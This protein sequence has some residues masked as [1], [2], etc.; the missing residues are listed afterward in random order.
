MD[1][2]NTTLKRRSTLRV[3]A[4]SDPELLM[5]RD[6][7]LD[8][9]EFVHLALPDL[10]LAAVDTEVMFLGRRL[11]APLVITSQAGGDGT[12]INRHLAV[13]AQEAGVALAL[14]P[15][16]IALTDDTALADFR[17]RDQ[18]PEIPVYAQLE[19]C[20][21]DELCTVDAA[22]EL[23]AKLDADALILRLNAFEEALAGIESITAAGA[24]ARIGAIVEAMRPDNI[25]VMV[26]EPGFGL[27][28]AASRALMDLRVD[29]V[30]VSGAGGISPARCAARLSQEPGLSRVGT[31]FGDWG[32]SLVDSI[33]QIRTVSD[34]LPIVAGG[35]VR[36]G[37]DAAKLLALGSDVISLS[38]PF[39][40]A[41]AQGPE[42]VVQLCQQL[43]TELRLTMYGVGARSIEELRSSQ[44]LHQR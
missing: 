12:D 14:G 17:V 5:A 7:G 25:P 26:L 4:C 32:M 29:A 41:A 30:H 40:A 31:V 38:S 13:A 35:G 3:A 22:R 33:Q 11:K 21:G 27:D 39:M 20:W 8:D 18:A 44:R 42:A 24:L 16:R 28:L 19:L 43:I 37:L 6:S 9:H 34:Q 15:G 1:D 36:H 10:D 2:R 23:V